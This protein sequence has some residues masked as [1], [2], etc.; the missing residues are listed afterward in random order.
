MHQENKKSKAHQRQ[1]LRNFEAE[2]REFFK[3]FEAGKKLDFL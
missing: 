1:I 2:T 3:T